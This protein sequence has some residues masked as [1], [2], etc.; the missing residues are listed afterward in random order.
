MDLFIRQVGRTLTGIDGLLSH[1]RVL[2]C[3]RDRKW[4]RDV[5]RLLGDGRVYVVQAPFRRPMRTPTPSGSYGRLNM[6]A[7]IELCRSASAT[8]D[9]HSRN[10][11][12]TAIASGITKGSKIGLSMGTRRGDAPAGF[13]GV[14]G[15]VAC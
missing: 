10:S 14:R 5:R 1:H 9:G 6:S 8:F 7:S 15:S 12:I 4:S 3:D 11:S 13:V 2:I